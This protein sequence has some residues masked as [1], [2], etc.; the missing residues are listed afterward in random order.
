MPTLLIVDLLAERKAFGEKGV[1]EIINHFPNHEVQLWA[2]HTDEPRDYGFGIRIQEPAEADVIVITGS[3]RNVS[4]WEPWMDDVADL[5]RQSEVPIYGICFGHQI[6]CK[7]LGGEVVRAESDS[8]FIA[9][10]KYS[11]GTSSMQLF[12]HQDHVIDAGEMNV[13]GSSEH[14]KIAVCEHPTRPIRTVQFHPEAVK[15]LLE[16]SVECGDMTIEERS[17]FGNGEQDYNVTDSLILPKY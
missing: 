17:V 8:K 7:A 13:V 12:T 1:E 11:N 5:I 9:E 2:P 16:F 3:R 10:V 14:C 4:M 6:I 15:S